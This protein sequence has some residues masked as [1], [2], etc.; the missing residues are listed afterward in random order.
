MRAGRAGHLWV[1]A[2]LRNELH[3][4]RL[5][6]ARIVGLDRM[7]MLSFGRGQWCRR[8]VV[9]LFGHGNIVLLDEAWIV[10]AMLRAHKFEADPFVRRRFPFHRVVPAPAPPSVA[11]VAAALSGVLA[12]AEA[13]TGTAR[14]GLRAASSCRT[15]FRPRSA[16]RRWR[17]TA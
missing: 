1:V 6:H 17:R 7:L 2:K 13:G 14:C 11:A 3:G 10:L 16:R 12:E 9:E 4:K 15:G 5:L 8:V